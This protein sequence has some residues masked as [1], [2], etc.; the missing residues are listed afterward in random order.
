MNAGMVP[1]LTS[2]GS[3]MP[4]L[5]LVEIMR[6]CPKGKWHHGNVPHISLRKQRGGKV[7]RKW[8]RCPECTPEALIVPDTAQSAWEIYSQYGAHE[9]AWRTE[10]VI[11]TFNPDEA[12]TA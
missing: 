7:L 12:S 3:V 2:G 4:I 9:N 5:E 6:F 8:F 1:S 11:D 10:R